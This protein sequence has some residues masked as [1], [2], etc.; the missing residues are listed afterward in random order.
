M[1]TAL[2]MTANEPSPTNIIAQQQANI[3]NLEEYTKA[4]P[5]KIYICNEKRENSFEENP[6][7]RF[8]QWLYYKINN[9][10]TDPQT[11]E[12]IINLTKAHAKFAVPLKEDLVIH[13]NFDFYRTIQRMFDDSITNKPNFAMQ[14]LLGMPMAFVYKFVT[15]LDRDIYNPFS[16]EIIARSGSQETFFN[17]LAKAG[18]YDGI[19]AKQDKGNLGVNAHAALNRTPLSLFQDWLTAEIQ[20]LMYNNTDDGKNLRAN[21]ANVLQTNISAKILGLIG[22]ILGP[23][24][25]QA[26][27]LAIGKAILTGSTAKEISELVLKNLGASTAGGAAGLVAGSLGGRLAGYTAT[28]LGTKNWFYNEKN[29]V[30]PF[31]ERR[32]K[33]KQEADAEA[34][35][36]KVATYISQQTA[37]KTRRTLSGQI[38]DD[39][40]PQNVISADQL[41]EMRKTRAE[42]LNPK[43]KTAAAIPLAKAA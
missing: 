32:A 34:D 35:E 9:I 1:A 25:V 12:E 24:F 11:P 16:R 23:A 30:I 26:S 19:R 29:N 4:Y 21:A 10:Q 38:A 3:V 14:I 7:S 37:E 8:L 6:L 17:Q 40:P 15:W 39:V 18:F 5:G 33:L 31:A 2:R 28:D 41:A 20:M 22:S 36:T 27:G 42:A 43:A 13:H